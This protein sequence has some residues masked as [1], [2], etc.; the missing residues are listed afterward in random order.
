MDI[1]FFITTMIVVVLGIFWA[2]VLYYIIKIVRSINRIVAKVQ[3]EV[4]EISE[5]FSVMKKEVKE[6][7]H[8]V[9]EGITTAKNYTKAVAGAGIVRAVSGLFEAFMEEKEGRKKRK[10]KTIEK[11]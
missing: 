4:D 6:G 5:D 3:K 10:K 7:I 8:D 11:K 9:R 2:I 1:F